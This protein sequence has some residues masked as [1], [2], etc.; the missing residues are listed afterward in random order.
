MNN[1]TMLQVYVP[2]KENRRK[3][4]SI[5]EGIVFIDDVLQRILLSDFLNEMLRKTVVAESW[6]PKLN[7]FSF[8]V[9][10][11]LL[12]YL[13]ARKIKHKH[14]LILKPK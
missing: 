3:I 12:N 10:D 4:F 2:E 9:F 14:A 6:G 11:S 7:L 5:V 1:L 8:E 13:I